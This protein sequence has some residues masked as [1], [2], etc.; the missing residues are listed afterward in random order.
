MKRLFKSLVFSIM[1]VFG[2]VNIAPDLNA[3]ASAQVAPE[4]KT[5]KK[6]KAKRLTASQLKK[7]AAAKKKASLAKKKAAARKKA[8]LAKKRGVAKNKASATKKKAIEKR[9]A[10]ALS[11]KKSAKAP[12]RP[13]PVSYIWV[14]NPSWMT[15]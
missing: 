2:A 4:S 10:S 6:K 15:A 11:K 9:K 7:R 5:V 3:S 8:S 1:L 14:S 12:P 13:R